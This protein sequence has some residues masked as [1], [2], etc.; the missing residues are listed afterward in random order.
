MPPQ[1]TESGIRPE[2]LDLDQRLSVTTAL[3]GTVHYSVLLR[4]DEYL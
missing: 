4:S 2:C 3:D 1:P